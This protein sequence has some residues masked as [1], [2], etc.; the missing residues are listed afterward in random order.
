ME[1][2]QNEIDSW[3][4]AILRFANKFDEDDNNTNNKDGYIQR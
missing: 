2:S 4:I 3:R 1:I